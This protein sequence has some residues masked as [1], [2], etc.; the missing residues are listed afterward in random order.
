MGFMK[1]TLP[2]LDYRQWSTQPRMARLKPMVLHWATNGF[3]TPDAV[4]FL[5]ILKLV[6]FLGGAI[7]VISLTPGLGSFA[8]VASWW[9]E[10]IVYQKLVI[11]TLLWEVVGF[12]GGFGP[13]TLRF[14][15]PVGG[16]L[17]WLRPGTI[18]LPPWPGRV[19]F[20]RGSRRS[21]VDVS[22]YAG[23]LAAAVF[24]LLAPATRASGLPGE[25][26]LLAAD[27]VLPLLILLPLLGLRDKTIFLAARSEVYLSATAAFLLP[28]VDMIV[29][30]KLI[31]LA[32]WVGAAVSKLSHHF[33]YVIQ[34][35][36]SNNP[37][38]RSK[39]L[40]RKFYRNYPDDMR[41]SALA[42]F[43]AHASTV[44]E[45]AVPIVL[46]C[47]GGGMVTTV[48][49]IVMVIFHLNILISLPAGVPLEWNVYMLTGIGILFVH[50]AQY[51]VGDLTQ[52]LPV[53]LL[54]AALVAGVVVGHLNPRK[55]SFL[56]GMRYYAGN[57][58]TSL[59]C[60]TPGA[61]A[62][63]EESITKP[64]SLPR[65]QL[66]KLY[67]DEVADLISHKGNVFRL[68]HAHGRALF[69]LIP[70]AC[71]PDHETKYIP[72]DGD[73]V[74][75]VTLGWNFA[76][77]H[78]HNEQLIQAVHERCHFDEGE[79]RVIVLDAQPIHRQRQNYRLVDAATGEF[80]RGYVTVHDMRALQPW[81]GSIPAHPETRPP[82]PS[83]H[84]GHDAEIA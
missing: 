56:I 65:A 25:L 57:W 48:A 66:A 69:G 33:P 27:R 17:Y 43:V 81:A 79:L 34:V 8:S 6:G 45:F 13:L 41:P 38:L 20:T 5:Y 59:W 82:A 55:V 73:F 40:K 67:G 62:K 64:A 44:V 39:W 47:S 75:G 32:I 31:F 51:N 72:V 23:V 80:E 3:G 42:T 68:M 77:G 84:R 53:A 70:R 10:A 19:P 83:A 35:M 78:M 12:G 18:R 49:A 1:P 28:G 21:I 26:G 54:V 2:T 61:V 22:L 30:A 15:P 71:G 60:L 76:D 63:L 36:V 7:F 52:P 9:T 24:A 50:H 74:A 16:F 58:D 4:Y 29:A 46:F 14:L 37:V 11:W